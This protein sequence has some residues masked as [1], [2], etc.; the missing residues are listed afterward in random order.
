MWKNRGITRIGALNLF[1]RVRKRSRGL[2]TVQAQSSA[3]P[4]KEDG[5]G[6]EGSG[7]EAKVEA[8]RTKREVG[9]KII[10]ACD[11]ESNLR[12]SW[13]FYVTRTNFE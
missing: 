1:T 8:S 5:V 6:A 2:S 10:V 4:G 9:K 7:T 12:Y 13:V 11:G 3:G